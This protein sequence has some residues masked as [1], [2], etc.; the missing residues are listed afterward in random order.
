MLRRGRANVDARRRWRPRVGLAVGRA[1]QLPFPDAT[2]DA[3]T[4][5][6]LL[7]YVADPAATLRELARVLKPGAPIASLEFLVPPQPV[8]AVL[9]VAVHARR[10]PGRGLPDRR[11][12]VVRGRALPRTEHLDALPTATRVRL[13]RRRVAA[14]RA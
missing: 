6:Y 14:T 2:F 3:L 4:F 10:A 1:E 5:T 12:R 7:R 8:L 9:V 11:P 13:D